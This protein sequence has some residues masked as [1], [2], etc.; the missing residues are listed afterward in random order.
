MASLLAVAKIPSKLVFRQICRILGVMLPN[1]GGMIG[2]AGRQ[3]PSAGK[4]KETAGSSI[5][6][7]HTSSIETRSREHVGRRMGQQ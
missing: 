2:P 4:A 1:R 7:R 6:K 3:F 5:G